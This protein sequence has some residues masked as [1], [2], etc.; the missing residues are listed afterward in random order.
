MPA[1]RRPR[2]TRPSP[3]PVRTRIALHVEIDVAAET[4]RL[5]KEIDRLAGEIAKS[6]AKLG[7]ANFVARAKPEVVD[8]ERKRV[9]DFTATL[10]RL[11]DQRERLAT[12]H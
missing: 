6:E 4:V 1:S 7:N 3:W 10:S 11:R 2:A 9:V 8:Q 12:P 5:S